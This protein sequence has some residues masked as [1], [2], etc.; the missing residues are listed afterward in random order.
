M[1]CWN[2]NRNFESEEMFKVKFTQKVTGYS[3]ICHFCID[4]V[5]KFKELYPVLQQKGEIMSDDYVKPEDE[6]EG[7]VTEDDLVPGD[8]V[9]AAPDEYGHDQNESSEDVDARLEDDD[10]DNDDND[11]DDAG[12]A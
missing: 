9:P 12:T 6:P 3:V 10:D 8:D 7:H 2:C 4:C 11:D 5:Y 1:R